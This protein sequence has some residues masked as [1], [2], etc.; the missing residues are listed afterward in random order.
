METLSN[1]FILKLLRE[2]R[3]PIIIIPES[4]ITESDDID[5]EENFLLEGMRARD[6]K[7]NPHIRT[8]ATSK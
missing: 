7:I 1:A 4:M 6:K 8:F 5:E 2:S 3:M